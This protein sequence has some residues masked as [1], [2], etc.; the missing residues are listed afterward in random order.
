MLIQQNLV[1]PILVRVSILLSNQCHN[2]IFLIRSR[3]VGIVSTLSL[4]SRRFVQKDMF[5]YIEIV[6]SSM[7]KLR[8]P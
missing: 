5:A 1:L 7:L 4:D 3:L 2:M 6:K 8:V